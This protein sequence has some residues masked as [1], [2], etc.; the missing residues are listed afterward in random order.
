MKVIW[1]TFSFNRQ[2]STGRNQWMLRYVKSAA[3]PNYY[4]NACCMY[5]SSASPNIGKGGGLCQLPC[6]DE[7][8]LK[9]RNYLLP[10]ALT[11]KTCRYYFVTDAL[12]P[13]S[14]EGL[15]IFS[16]VAWNN[17]SWEERSKANTI[18]QL[19]DQSLGTA[20]YPDLKAAFDTINQRIGRCYDVLSGIVPVQSRCTI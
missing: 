1:S 9:T 17:F 8:S 19:F 4:S 10:T 3:V 15:W 5:S 13:C 12:K 14:K 16:L 11:S 2:I 20:Y 18:R 6:S 7:M